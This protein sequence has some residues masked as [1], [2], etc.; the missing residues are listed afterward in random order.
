MKW[1]VQKSFQLD[2]QLSSTQD[3]VSPTLDVDSLGVIGIQNRINNVDSSVSLSMDMVTL[4]VVTE[5]N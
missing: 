2:V 5:I 1:V 4:M 3:N